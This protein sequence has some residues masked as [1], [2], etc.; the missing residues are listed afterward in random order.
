MQDALFAIASCD[1]AW[2]F[3]ICAV[4]DADIGLEEDIA[5]E[6]DDVEPEPDAVEPELDDIDPPVD[7]ANAP[8]VAAAKTRARQVDCSLDM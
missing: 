3:F 4:C 8:V 5:P 6:P 7:W 2:H 1:M